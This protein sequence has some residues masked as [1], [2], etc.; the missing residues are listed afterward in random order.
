MK[1]AGLSLLE[2]VATVAILGVLAALALPR[3]TGSLDEGKRS[4]CFVQ[5]AE[6]ELQ[7]MRWRKANGTWPAT[8]LTDIAIDPDYFPEG[9][10]TCPVDGSSYAIDGSTGAVIGHTH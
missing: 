2:L 1:R 7:A 8:T 9:V 5:R 4:A 10:P 3:V 6:I